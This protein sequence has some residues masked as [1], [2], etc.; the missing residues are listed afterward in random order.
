MYLYAYSVCNSLMEYV[1]SYNKNRGLDQ[2][3]FQDD[4]REQPVMG[5][6]NNKHTTITILFNTGTQTDYN[7]ATNWVLAHTRGYFTLIPLLL[8]G[9]TKGGSKTLYS[10]NIRYLLAHSTDIKLF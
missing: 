5:K 2:Y 3:R 7:I 4:Y 8:P 10:I 9:N 1:I 6:S